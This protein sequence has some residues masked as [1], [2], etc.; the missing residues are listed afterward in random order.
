MPKQYSMISD[1]TVLELSLEPLLDFSE[2]L[3]IC[4][5]IS[6]NDTFWKSLKITDNPKISFIEGGETRLASVK[7]AV[8]FWKKSSVVYENVLIHDSVRPC[9]RSSDIRTMLESFSISGDHGAILGSPV[10]DSLKEVIEVGGYI[11]KTVDRNNL[12]KVFTPQI[13]LKDVLESA[14]EGLSKEQDFSDESGLV[15]QSFR[16]IKTYTGSNDNIKI[17]Y[18]E[19]MNLA[20][21]ILMTQG[22]LTE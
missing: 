4:I 15:E 20:K 1:K 3:G 7:R 8:N 13:F 12:W 6:S 19:D 14:F 9:V 22:R 16:K 5:P 18:P 10:I 2:C 17:T 21:S 11:K